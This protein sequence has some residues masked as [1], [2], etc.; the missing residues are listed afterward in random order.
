MNHNYSFN[1]I[2]KISKINIG[3]FLLFYLLCLSL[4]LPNL[5]LTQSVGN[6]EFYFRDDDFNIKT[7]LSNTLP[8]KSPEISG[9]RIRYIDKGKEVTLTFK[10]N[11]YKRGWWV[12]NDQVSID[13]KREIVIK[14]TLKKDIVK[15][16][17]TIKETSNIPSLKGLEE[18]YDFTGSRLDNIIYKREKFKKLRT[19][20]FE[21]E[22]NVKIDYESIKFVKNGRYFITCKAE[23]HSYNPIFG[24]GEPGNFFTRTAESDIKKYDDKNM[25]AKKGKNRK[26]SINLGK[27]IT[28]LKNL[29]YKPSIIKWIKEF[30]Y[31]FKN[32]LEAIETIN[33]VNYIKQNLKK[34][35]QPSSSILK[36][37]EEEK[38]ENEEKEK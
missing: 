20:F 8:E 32:T 14:R 10:I 35:S 18:E 37:F 25:R 11:L 26:S 33:N 13:G 6:L 12:F 1:R 19:L 36:K 22:I 23:Y 30:Y 28:F 21:K 7:K 29:I 31:E 5:G 9:E 15:K 4:L 17:Y 27:D 24:T 16:I 3:G 34:E 38:K 2:K